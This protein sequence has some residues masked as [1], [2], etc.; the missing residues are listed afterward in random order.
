M[1]IIQNLLYNPNSYSTTEHLATYQ[2]LLSDKK[3]EII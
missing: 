3:P 2:K 1:N